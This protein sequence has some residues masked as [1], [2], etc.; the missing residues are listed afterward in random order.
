MRAA[1]AATTIAATQSP[2]VGSTSNRVLP[3]SVAA[4]TTSISSTPMATTSP[5]CILTA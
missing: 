2:T 5:A 4:A 1:S 3:P